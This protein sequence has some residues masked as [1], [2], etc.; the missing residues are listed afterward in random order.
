M[1]PSTYKT[2]KMVVVKMGKVYVEL[3][4]S[5]Y[6]ACAHLQQSMMLRRR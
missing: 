6:F 5:V 4:I 1:C 2:D 3:G